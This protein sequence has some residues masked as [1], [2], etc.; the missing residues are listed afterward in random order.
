MADKGGIFSKELKKAL[1]YKEEIGEILESNN[2]DDVFL[3]Y[4]RTIKL[5]DALEEKLREATDEL[6]DQDKP[7]TEAREYSKKSKEELKPLRHVRDELKSRLEELEGRERA[8]KEE[9]LMRKKSKI[10]L[11]L[12]KARLE[13]EGEKTSSS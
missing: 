1:F 6:I 2:R 5:I 3:E 4:Q 10:E 9:K 8:L 12:A 13:K 7:L 11:D